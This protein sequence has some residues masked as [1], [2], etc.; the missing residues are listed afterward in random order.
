MNRN[1]PTADFPDAYNPLGGINPPPSGFH[2]PSASHS[3]AFGPPPVSTPTDYQVVY[4]ISNPTPAFQ[5]PSGN[6][7]FATAAGDRA[8]ANNFNN[9]SPANV[10]APSYPSYGWTTGNN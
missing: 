8:F 5:T 6:Q 1:G 9:N 2:P 4:S 10:A 7:A 3:S